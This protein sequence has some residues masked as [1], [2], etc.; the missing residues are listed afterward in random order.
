MWMNRQWVSEFYKRSEAGALSGSR[1]S[2]KEDWERE[3]EI[4][5][6]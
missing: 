6:V 4:I 1:T 3:G 5:G 2:L